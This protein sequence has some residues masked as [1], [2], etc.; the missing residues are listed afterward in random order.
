MRVERL[1]QM[2]A[3]ILSK[4]T[5]TLYAL[6]EHFDISL[7]TVRRDVADLIDRGHIRKV[8]GGVSVRHNP[9]SKPYSVLL[10]FAKRTEMHPQEKQIIGTIAAS[11]VEDDS[12]VFLDS[13]STVPYMLPS[14]AEKNATIV[15]HSLSV[16]LEATKYPNLRVLALGGK[17]N[18]AT[19][20]LVGDALFGLRSIRLHALFMAATALSVEWGASNNTYEE[21]RLKSE[22]TQLHSRIYMLA[23]SSKFGKNATYCYCP[24]TRIKG[25]VTDKLPNPAFLKAMRD[26]NIKLYYPGTSESEALDKDQ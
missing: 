13:G 16:M 7:N 9:D 3:Y 19:N 11:L 23:D 10:P 14:L 2:E 6:S 1:N 24:F 4:G 15:T 5:V 25:I 21:Y 26:N 17:L 18:H 12:V 22:L 8:Y 20:S